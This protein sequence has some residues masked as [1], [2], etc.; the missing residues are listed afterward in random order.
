MATVPWPAIVYGSS[1]AG[2]MVAPVALGVGQR[3]RVGVVVGVAHHDDLDVVAAD[4]GDPG[5]L[6]PGGVAGQED[7][8]VDPE[9][10]ARVREPL[11]V[12][13]GAGAHHA[14]GPGV[15]VEPVEH[16]VGAPDLVR[17]DHLQVLALD[18]HLDPEPIGQPRTRLQS[19]PRDHPVQRGRRRLHHPRIDTRLGPHAP[20][21]AHAR[22]GG[23]TVPRARPT[24]A[25]PARCAPCPDPARLWG[26]TGQLDPAGE[27]RR[28]GRRGGRSGRGRAR[29][30]ADRSRRLAGVR[31]RQ[32][33]DH[34]PAGRLDQRSGRRSGDRRSGRHDGRRRRG[35]AGARR[36]R[37]P[38]RAEAQAAEP[39]DL[40]PRRCAHA[41]GGQHPGRA[42]GARLPARRARPVRRLSHP[43]AADRRAAT[44]AGGP[45][46]DR[47]GAQ[48]LP[49]DRRPRHPGRD[50]GRRSGTDAG[51]GVQ[52]GRRG[53]DQ[54]HAARRRRTR[55]PRC[56]PAPTSTSPV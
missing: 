15:G 32:G 27:D 7:P 25:E 44:T 5:A 10:G 24:A 12:V 16:R 45:R 22:G 23:V 11:A 33:G 20:I 3:G 36:D 52:Q 34:G 1:K 9:R 19:G 31:P 38:A 13:A 8:A 4:G 29:R 54:D 47:R 39:G 35:G 56:P 18:E 51:P 14:P 42:G 6:L 48:E 41:P 37:R 26:A 46:A 17:P 49:Q 55:P 43:A 40:P 53:P 30:G 2:T 21:I 50:R 28:R